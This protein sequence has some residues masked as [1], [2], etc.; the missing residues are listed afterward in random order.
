MEA[1]CC[2]C[3]APPPRWRPVART[4]AAAPLPP[5]LS[6]QPG[7]LSQWPL[8]P[9]RKKAEQGPQSQASSSIA[10][11]SWQ[12]GNSLHEAVEGSKYLFFC[13]SF[14]FEERVEQ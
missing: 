10:G 8:P 13:F 2:C 4:V 7:A 9:S 3:W 12:S 14:L 1:C 11:F 6:E 5:L